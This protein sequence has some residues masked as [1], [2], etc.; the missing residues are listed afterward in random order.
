MTATALTHEQRIV[1]LSPARSRR[2]IVILTEDSKPALGGIAEYLHQ[3]ALAA[4]ATHEIVIVTSVHGAESLNPGLPFQ[5]REVRW[6]RAQERMFGDRMP[7]LR[8]I[9]TALWRLGRRGRVRALVAA[10][11]VERANTSYVL[12]RLSPTTFPWCDACMDLGLSYSAIGYGLELIEPLSRTLSQRRAR[13]AAE[14]VHWFAISRDTSEKLARLGVPR[15]RQSLLV[16]GV[17]SVETPTAA[18]RSQA[19]IRLDIGQ[20]KFVF[21]LCHLRRRKG[22]DLAIRAFSAVASEFPEL[23]YV[24]AGT[25]PEEH[26]LAHLVAELGLTA[27]VLF[28]GPIDDA[29]KNSLYA[30]C[31]FFVLPNRADECDVEGFGI[32]F[33]EAGLYGKAVI[34]GDNG[35]VPEAVVADETGLLVDTRDEVALTGAMRRLL[36]DPVEADR[37]GRAACQRAKKDFSWVGRAQ[38]FVGDATWMATG[39]NRRVSAGGPPLADPT[40]PLRR[41]FLSGVSVGVALA[42]EGRLA[43]YV[44]AHARPNDVASCTQSMLQWLRRAFAAGGGQAAAAGYHIVNGWAGAYPEVTGYTIR[45]LLDYAQHE[46]DPELATLARQAGLW[47]VATRLPG[48]AICRKQWYEG[49]NTPSVFN[50]GQVLE[51]WCALA[52]ASTADGLIGRAARDAAEWLLGEQEAD[53]SWVRSAYNGISHSYYARVAGPL[54][55]YARL[56]GDD[57]VAAAA[58]WACDWVLTLQ[59]RDGWVH[60]AGFIESDE[61]TSHTIGYVLEGLLQVGLTLDEPRYVEGAELGARALLRIYRDIGHL[62]GR[63]GAHWRPRARWRCLTGDAQVA[64]VWCA[65]SRVTGDSAFRMA[66]REVADSLRRSVTV[67]DGWPEISGALPGSAPPWGDY[68]PYGYPT[69]AVKFALDLFSALRETEQTRPVPTDS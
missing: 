27:R 51:G 47:L 60:R 62:P 24:V 10:I 22:I 14:A 36:R 1:A 45:T 25:G 32:V 39:R 50:T 40:A 29:T 68:D 11:D 34:G 9:N 46:Q 17:A 19:R 44:G 58:R 61:P 56:T 41:Q 64:L 54:A 4:S 65:L 69:H 53:G 37:L 33:L 43:A 42:R 3:L 30:E 2:R 59:E 52:R 13:L 20:R 18:A 66:A 12:G 38:D 48:G 28:A 16:P 49:N 15:T 31:E 23:V 67:V 35:G 21:S 5:Y 7:G 6:F 8:Q 55:G 57:R 26:A 63:I